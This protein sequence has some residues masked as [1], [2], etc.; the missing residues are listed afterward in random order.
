L[1]LSTLTLS[2][3]WIEDYNIL[4]PFIFIIIARAVYEILKFIKITLLICEITFLIFSL[5]IIDTIT[6]FSDLPLKKGCYDY[7]KEIA[8]KIIQLNPSLLVGDTAHTT[9]SIEFYLL[10]KNYTKVY[11]LEEENEKIITQSLDKAIFILGWG[12]CGTPERFLKRVN[13]IHKQE[14]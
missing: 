10:L 11:I 8:W 5:L 7:A 14:S 12:K 9:R 6:Y 2:K 13:S 3:F 1:F 4:A